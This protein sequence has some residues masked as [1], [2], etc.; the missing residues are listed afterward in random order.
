MARHTRSTRKKSLKVYSA[1]ELEQQ[2]I[3]LRKFRNLTRSP[4][5]AIVPEEG[6]CWVLAALLRGAM[7]EEPG[8]NAKQ[9]LKAADTEID[10]YDT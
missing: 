5:V 1:D 10:F 9:F 6:W 2:K 8:F 7:L 3:S 4:D